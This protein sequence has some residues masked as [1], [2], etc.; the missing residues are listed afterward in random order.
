MDRAGIRLLASGAISLLIALPAMAGTSSPLMA[1]FDT[2]HDGHVSLAEYQ[3][4]MARGF[5]RLDANGDGV[6][7]PDEFPRGTHAKKPLTQAAHR[8]Q[9]ARQF[10]R[11]DVNH[12]GFLD[13]RELAAP[14]R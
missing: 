9:V 6:I 5:A 8:R 14:P 10:H 4:Y 13:A 1:L 7:E 12:D 11:Q 3:A 2:N